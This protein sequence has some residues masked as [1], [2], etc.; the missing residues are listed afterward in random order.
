M[1]HQRLSEVCRN[2]WTLVGALPF[3]ATMGNLPLK[4]AP[5]SMAAPPRKL[6]HAELLSLR[7]CGHTR[8]DH[9]EKMRGSGLRLETWSLF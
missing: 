3:L 1:T 2:L 8:N 7:I 5:R 9:V 6:T 4:N